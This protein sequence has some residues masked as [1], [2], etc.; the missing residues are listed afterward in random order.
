MSIYRLVTLADAKANARIVSTDE[1]AALQRLV[2]RASRRIMNYLEAEWARARQYSG[3]DD[4]SDEE[5]AAA[6]KAFGGWTD[7]SGIPLVDSNG[8]PLIVDYDTDSNGD[9]VL[10]SN[11]GYVG[12]RSIIPADVE[13]ATLLM[14]DFLY[15]HR[16]GDK[17]DITQG[18]KSCLV[19]Y[20][21]PTV[22]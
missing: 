12:G 18:V 11:G 4:V 6:E 7:S 22:A 19:R 14:F 16:D 10:D 20:R 8:D 17:D 13:I 9:P 2:D 15:E 5:I 3:D 1:D 21:P